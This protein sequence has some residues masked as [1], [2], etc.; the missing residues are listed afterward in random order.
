MSRTYTTNQSI[1][2]IIIIIITICTVGNIEKGLWQWSANNYIFDSILKLSQ[3]GSVMSRFCTV[4]DNYVG[5]LQDT[6]GQI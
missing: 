6:G 4:L 3:R 1:L 5:K 2:I